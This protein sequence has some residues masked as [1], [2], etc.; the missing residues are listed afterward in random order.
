MLRYALTDDDFIFDTRSPGR[1]PQRR[2]FTT[3]DTGGC[4]CEQI[5]D[6]LGLGSGQSK[7][8]CS[9][10]AMYVWSLIVEVR[11]LFEQ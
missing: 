10:G 9:L 5:I 8:G 7:F 4:S 2:V 11:Q 3:V 6:E 1:Y